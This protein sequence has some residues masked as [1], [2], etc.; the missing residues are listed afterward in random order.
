MLFSKKIDKSVLSKTKSYLAKNWGTGGNGSAWNDVL[1][2][3]RA[4][5][6]SIGQLWKEYTKRDF[7]M[8]SSVLV[9]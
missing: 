6:K 9:Y 4:E 8:L 1:K 2:G 7:S 5:K 3:T